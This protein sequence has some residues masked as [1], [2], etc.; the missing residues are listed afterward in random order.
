MNPSQYVIKPQKEGGGNNLYNDDVKNFLLDFV[1]PNR[2]NEHQRDSLKQNLIMQRINPPSTKTW[3]LKD[4]EV[5]QVVSSSELGLFSCII[6]DT[7]LNQVIENETF[8]LLMRTKLKESNEGGVYAG[9]AVIDLPVLVDDTHPDFYF[10][11][12]P[13]TVKPN[14]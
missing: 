1:T 4:A 11:D 7:S 9:Y 2:L 12:K 14:I 5:N 13:G 10:Y 8:G 6:L 3:I